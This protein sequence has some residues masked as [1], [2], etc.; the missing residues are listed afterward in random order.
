M[1]A[2]PLLMEQIGRIIKLVH[3]N[4]NAVK[5]G[6]I[7]Q[8]KHSIDK[9]YYD[10]AYNLL[11]SKQGKGKMRQRASTV[12]PVLGSLLNYRRLKKVYTIGQELAQKQILMA[13][14]L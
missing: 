2:F 5:K 7:K 11:N 8:L 9:A 13:A 6:N 4:Q 14:S 10:K 12:E 1:E 3:L